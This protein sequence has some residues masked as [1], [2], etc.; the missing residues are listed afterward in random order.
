MKSKK[1]KLLFTPGPLTTS[2]T[3]KVAG[4][5]DLGSRD[6][7]F[8]NVVKDIRNDLLEIAGVSKDTGWESVIMQGSGTFGVESVLTSVIPPKGKVLILINGAYGERMAKICEIHKIEHLIITTPENQVP[9]PEEVNKFI[10]VTPGLTHL[11]IVHC[12]TTTGIINPVSEFG[13]LAHKWGLT[14]IVDSMS[15]FGA[16]DLTIAE[17]EADFL[18]SSSN[19]CI[20]G[21][22]GFSFIICRADKLLMAKGNARTLSL[23]L[24]A[25]WLSLESNGQFRFTPPIQ[26]LLSFK[27]AINEL[28]K[29]GGPAGREKRYSNNNEILRK[30]MKELGFDEYLENNAGYIITSYLYPKSQNFDF[31]RFYAK[32]NERGMVIYPG[33]LSQA[34]CF[35]IGNIGDLHAG[36]IESL[37]KHIKEVKDEMSF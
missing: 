1:D 13:K 24:Y 11:A 4:F 26:S 12:E 8:I 37:L 14:Y 19:K 35:R 10:A 27:Q 20:Q 16:T 5:R 30:G 28:K 29:E 34:D 15:I 36:D 31:N 23:D 6:Y 25:Q 2:D 22:P 21:I 17:I 9:N 18:V 7:E 33:K 3:V 32:L